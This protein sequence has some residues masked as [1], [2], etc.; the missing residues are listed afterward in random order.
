MYWVTKIWIIPYTSPTLI[1]GIF[2]PPVNGRYLFTVYAV[3]Y[4][5]NG[6]MHLRKGSTS[7]CRAWLESTDY[8]A[9]CTAAVSDNPD[10]SPVYLVLYWMYTNTA[11]IHWSTLMTHW[12]Y[13]NTVLHWGPSV[14]TGVH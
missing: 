8:S 10:P 2:R 5:D 3:S 6:R 12:A 9:S 1:A 14:Y 13:T 11:S 4:G 7:L